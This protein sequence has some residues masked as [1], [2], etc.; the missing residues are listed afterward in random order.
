VGPDIERKKTTLLSVE[1][2]RFSR[3]KPTLLFGS[4]TL[5]EEH[6]TSLLS[7]WLKQQKGWIAATEDQS[8]PM[9]SA[10]T[11]G[12]LSVVLDLL[13]KGQPPESE[14]RLGE[15]TLETDA[16]G[17][18]VCRFPEL[19][20]KMESLL[21]GDY[22]FG[23][24]RLVRKPDA[25]GVWVPFGEVS[26]ID[27]AVLYR[28]R[29]NSR[30]QCDSDGYFFFDVRRIHYVTKGVLLPEVLKSGNET[31]LTSSPWE[32]RVKDPRISAYDDYPRIA[33]PYPIQTGFVL[34]FGEV[35]FNQMTFDVRI[36][37]SPGL[38]PTP[39]PD[40]TSMVFLR[41]RR[42][43]TYLITE[44]D[45]QAPIGLANKD[46]LIV[47]G[48]SM[49]SPPLDLFGEVEYHPG[50][51]LR[52][53]QD[54]ESRYEAVD[55]VAPTVVLAPSWE[56]QRLI[57]VQYQGEQLNSAYLEIHDAETPWVE[58]GEPSK[59]YDLR[60]RLIGLRSNEGDELVP[61][62]L[63]ASIPTRSREAAP[64]GQW[65]VAWSRGFA[66]ACIFLPPGHDGDLIIDLP[67]KMVSVRVVLES[68]PLGGAALE[69]WKP[70]FPSDGDR[71][72]PW[73]IWYSGI[74]EN[75]SSGITANIMPGRTFEH[76]LTLD[77]TVTWVFTAETHPY[78]VL[79]IVLPVRSLPP[80]Q[81]SP[82][83]LGGAVV[84]VGVI[85]APSFVPL[86]CAAPTDVVPQ[87]Y[88]P[89]NTI[90]RKHILI[91]LD[92][93]PSDFKP[94]FCDQSGNPP[95]GAIPWGINDGDRI[96]PIAY[97][98]DASAGGFSA[99]LSL[100]SR[101]VV[102]APFD[103][104]RDSRIDIRVEAGDHRYGDFTL[105]AGERKPFYAPVGET[106]LIFTRFDTFYSLSQRNGIREV[107][108][109]LEFLGRY[110]VTITTERGR[111]QPVEIDLT[112]FTMD[113]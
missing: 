106:R 92:G 48:M 52:R 64:L 84:K 63:P 61:R 105:L 24:G 8:T 58:G 2:S 62:S 102:Q 37:R 32:L 18:L 28:D 16:N 50:F 101:V 95:L 78:D 14:T 53:S 54:A 69:A 47:V 23:H 45:W 85:P 42:T 22:F 75:R 57:R 93:I 46:D 35:E 55:T 103:L 27:E 13:E 79:S 76:Q 67:A 26:L 88:E 17:I 83:I 9:S 99:A 1:S 107:A 56:R 89:H 96:I 12:P 74:Q 97:Q 81:L 19:V 87:D 36:D 68:S 100:E 10:T 41:F 30:I 94:K 71:T 91:L 113:D 5:N 112:K 25:R 39:G 44:T 111:V 7:T 82:P 104:G 34:D 60:T 77:P 73:Y 6:T 72:I 29:N 51:T 66:P 86:T 80:I 11:M 49:V 4:L 59:P 98:N 21:S 20:L 90:W 110:E 108:S 70:A 38:W 65:V 40:A 33:L 109:S 3:D 43:D 31:G 15:P